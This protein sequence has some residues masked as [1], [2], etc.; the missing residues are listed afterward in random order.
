MEEPE[1]SSADLDVIKKKIVFVC[2]HS[3]KLNSGLIPRRELKFKG[4]SS[5]PGTCMYDQVKLL[6][7]FTYT[8]IVVIIAHMTTLY[9]H[10]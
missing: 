5:S 10:V 1:W 6:I 4:S 3:S 9:I 7:L 8:C 2:F